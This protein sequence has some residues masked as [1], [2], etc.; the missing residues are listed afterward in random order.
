MRIFFEKAENVWLL[1]NSKLKLVPFLLIIFF[2]I[3]RWPSNFIQSY[4]G[5][6]SGC[7]Y[8]LQF[9]HFINRMCSSGT[10]CNLYQNSHKSLWIWMLQGFNCLSDL[11]TDGRSFPEGWYS[12]VCRIGNS[13]HKKYF[14][15]GFIHCSEY[16]IL[17]RDNQ[18]SFD[19]EWGTRLNVGWFRI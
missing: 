19:W 6:Q 1:R 17:A 3:F 16:G 11:S 14:C 2:Q 8:H 18:K 4:L 12:D 15:G 13:D 5:T 10:S 9:Y 7:H